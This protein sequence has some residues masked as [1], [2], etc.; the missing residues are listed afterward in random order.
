MFE[1]DKPAVI[2][3]GGDNLTADL[4]VASDGLHLTCREVVLGYRSPPQPTGQMVYKVTLPVEKLEGIPEL[5]DLVTTPRSNHWIGPYGTVLSY[6]LEGG[7]EKLINFVFT[8]DINGKLPDGI[9]QA[10]G[11][12]EDVRKAFQG[13]GARLHT[14]LSHVDKVLQWRVSLPVP[15]KI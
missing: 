13:W 9:N 1:P 10:V 12:G 11:T 5:E 8:R 3:Q 15:S 6:L 4:I 7:N 2:L 14:I